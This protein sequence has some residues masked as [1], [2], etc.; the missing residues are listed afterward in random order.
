MIRLSSGL[1]ERCWHPSARC[2][3]TPRP[4]NRREHTKTPEDLGPRAVHP[5]VMLS[6]PAF[7]TT[8]PPDL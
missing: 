5:P 2:R 8:R 1:S 7:F 4:E 6:I 3:T